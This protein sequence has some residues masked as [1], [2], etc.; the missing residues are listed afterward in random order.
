MGS[1]PSGSARLSDSASGDGV[2]RATLAD[3]PDRECRLVFGFALFPDVDLCSYLFG[4]LISC[5]LLVNIHRYWCVYKNMYKWVVYTGK[6]DAL[7]GRPKRREDLPSGAMCVH[8][9]AQK[10]SESEHKVP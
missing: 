8:D 2:R 4:M 9:P 1:K 6:P 3:S 7:N 10:H 5:H